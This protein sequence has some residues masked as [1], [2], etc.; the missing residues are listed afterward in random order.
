MKHL[1][2]RYIGQN[3]TEEST[4]VLKEEVRD[5]CEASWF[6]V[7][8]MLDEL[9]GEGLIYKPTNSKNA[10]LKLTKSGWK[11]YWEDKAKIVNVG[12]PAQLPP[13]K[14]VGVGAVIVD[15]VVKTSVQPELNMKRLHIRIGK[16]TKPIAQWNVGNFNNADEMELIGDCEMSKPQ[17]KYYGRWASKITNWGDFPRK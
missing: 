9:H 11:A 17:D 4:D 7:L 15:D 5:M 2:L 10:T 8:R 1:I 12:H 3:S 14:G 13:I 16:T 6:D